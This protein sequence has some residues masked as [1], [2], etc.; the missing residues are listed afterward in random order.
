MCFEVA[1][2][3]IGGRSRAGKLDLTARHA[4]RIGLTAVEV[5]LAAATPQKK[6]SAFSRSV[7]LLLLWLLWLLS[8]CPSCLAMNLILDK[9]DEYTDAPPAGWRVKFRDDATLILKRHERKEALVA[10][11]VF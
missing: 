2:S 6:I 7:V 3:E 11:T 8:C 5:K 10:A 9:G 4:L 1:Q